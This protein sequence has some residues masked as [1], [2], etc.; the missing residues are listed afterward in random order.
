MSI[1]TAEPTGAHVD[2]N[3]RSNW[4]THVD[5]NAG[6]CGCGVCERS[7]VTCAEAVLGAQHEDDVCVWRRT[8]LGEREG[9]GHRSAKTQHHKS[10]PA[11]PHCQSTTLQLA[12]KL[13]VTGACLS[14]ASPW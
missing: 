1:Q 9:E 4:R 6:H 2:P 10:M 13:N 7:G 8:G 11:G 5:P 14:M 3:G 12:L